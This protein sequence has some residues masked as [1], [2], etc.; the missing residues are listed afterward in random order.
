MPRM[1]TIQEA[2]TWVKE[3]D[4]DSALSFSALRKLV[5]S[6]EIPHV[7]IGAKRLI[8]LDTLEAYLS[9]EMNAPQ[10][11]TQNQSGIRRIEV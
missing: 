6:G 5:L 8:N 2:Y 1:R 11:T 7:A 4:P 10:P 9:G 3:K